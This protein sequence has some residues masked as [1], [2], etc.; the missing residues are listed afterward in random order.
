MDS[1]SPFMIAW[2]QYWKTEPSSGESI[3]HTLFSDAAHFD[4]FQFS[5]LHKAYLGINNIGFDKLL[6]ATSRNDLNATD[7]QGRTVLSW[8]AGRGDYETTYRLLVAGANPEIPSIDGWTALHYAAE[9]PDVQCMEI[10]LEFKADVNAPT[11]TRR[12][13]L[14]LA[15]DNSTQPE[16]VKCLKKH[17]AELDTKTLNGW[18]P[19][20][21]TFIQDSTSVA[22]QLLSMGAKCGMEDVN[23]AIQHNSHPILPLLLT[24]AG[25]DLEED[26]EDDYCA[27]HHAAHY[28]DL[29][30]LKILSTSWPDT[31]NLTARTSDGQTVL[32]AAKWRRDSNLEWS[33][34]NSQPLD[35]NSMLW[36]AAFE[37]MVE[38]I[39]DREKVVE[40]PVDSE[41]DDD[42]DIDDY[43]SSDETFSSP[44]EEDADF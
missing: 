16:K 6:A 34:E 21:R 2:E 19:L 33:R 42:E 17:G 23:L 15:V 39:Q 37:D 22:E 10:L 26:T 44:D 29:D 38:S 43:F 20:Q 9:A 18:T 27:F 35:E 25:L 4:D 13:S 24:H 14:H 3:A 5:E 40:T 30:T 8:A 36:Y 32:E 41:R 31:I 11:L 12:T 1:S 7:V 28:A